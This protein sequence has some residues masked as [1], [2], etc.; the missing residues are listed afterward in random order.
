MTDNAPKHGAVIHCFHTV[1]L[2]SSIVKIFFK[3]PSIEIVINIIEKN[4]ANIY[5]EVFLERS[6]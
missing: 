6:K 2:L 5:A 1:A 3:V 4:H